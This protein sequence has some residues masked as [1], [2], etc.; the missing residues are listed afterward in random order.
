MKL[1]ND[2]NELEILAD[3]K[4]KKHKG[5][6]PAFTLNMCYLVKSTCLSFDEGELLRFDADDE[7]LIKNARI[8]CRN[9]VERSKC[10]A[11]DEGWDEACNHLMAFCN[12]LFVQYKNVTF[13]QEDDSL[14]SQLVKYNPYI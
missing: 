13:K 8:A 14:Y 2:V 1:W 7:K 10:N 9:L 3:P 12:R 6:V 4:Y 11:F 5:P